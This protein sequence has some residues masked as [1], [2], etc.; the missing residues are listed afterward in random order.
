[1][2]FWS[3]APTFVESEAQEVVVSPQISGR[4]M[5]KVALATSA[6]AARRCSLLTN[7]RRNPSELPFRSV[8]VRAS[9]PFEAS[10]GP[11]TV[12]SEKKPP[13]QYVAVE[14]LS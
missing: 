14:S 4:R 11:E 3:Q 8:R 7:F 10:V 2:R 5:A 9:H 1:M 13:S 12:E 6:M